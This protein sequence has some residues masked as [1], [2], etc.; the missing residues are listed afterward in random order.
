MEVAIQ[1]KFTHAILPR[2][3]PVNFFMNGPGLLTRI[4]TQYFGSPACRGKQ[5]TFLLQGIQGLHQAFDQGGF[6]CSGIA[7]YHHD[8]TEIFRSKERPEFL[9]QIHLSRG[10]MKLQILLQ[11]GTNEFS[12][13]ALQILR[14]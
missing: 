4:G 9:N 8:L 5:Y 2:F 12:K 13:H 7:F 11:K 14:I 6:P 1:H 3:L 10:G